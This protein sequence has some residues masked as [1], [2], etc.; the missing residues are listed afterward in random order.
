M[1]RKNDKIDDKENRLQLITIISTKGKKNILWDLLLVSLEVV[2]QN[3]MIC[4]SKWLKTATISLTLL[5][6]NH[7]TKSEFES[8]SITNPKE[9]RDLNLIY[10]LRFWYSSN[11]FWHFDFDILTFWSKHNQKLQRRWRSFVSWLEHYP[12]LLAL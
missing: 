9:C 8:D 12:V 11:W 1:S 6:E 2:T 4:F 7:L 5:R 10:F 3:L